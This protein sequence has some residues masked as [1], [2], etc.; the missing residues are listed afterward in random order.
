MSAADTR[1]HENSLNKNTSFNYIITVSS[2][3]NVTQVMQFE[4][5]SLFKVKYIGC[6][7]Y[8]F[9]QQGGF[10]TMKASTCLHIT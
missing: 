10:I 7:F 5:L 6:F 9:P 1:S 8:C 2:N 4:Q 3:V